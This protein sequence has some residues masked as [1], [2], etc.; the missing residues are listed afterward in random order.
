MEAQ[1]LKKLGL[2]NHKNLLEKTTELLRLLQIKSSGLS[3]IDDYAKISIC[4][5]LATSLLGISTDLLDIIKQSGLKKTV[6][7]K[8]KRNIEKILNL[9][10]PLRISEICVHLNCNEVSEKA[11]N[12]LNMYED[13]INKS[14]DNDID[15][16]HPQYAAMAVFQ[17]CKL[18]KVK[19]IKAKILGFSHLRPSQWTRLEQQWDKF[20]TEY[21]DLLKKSSCKPKSVT[22]VVSESKEINSQTQDRAN[23]AEI[24][25]YETWKAR[26]INKAKEDLKQMKLGHMNKD[27]ESVN[28][29]DSL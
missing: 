8:Y 13:H 28:F 23:K 7:E 12:L 24:E 3:G 6:Y 2:Q 10:K 16:S 17:A 26:I 19:I 20:I 27:V 25:D 14:N 9:N 15:L 5:D 18:N 1:I 11:T 4:V 29:D 22:Q 21:N